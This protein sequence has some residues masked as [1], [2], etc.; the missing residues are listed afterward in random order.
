MNLKEMLTLAD[1]IIFTKSGQHLDDLQKTIL[2]GTL[3]RKTY[4]EI[5]KNIDCSESR[6]REIGAELWET[7]SEELGEKVK[8]TNFI[9][10]MERLQISISSKYFA[11]QES[12]QIGY[13]NYCV[14][15]K[16]PSNTQNQTPP[17]QQTT[18]P[19]QTPTLNHDLSEMPNLGTFYNR[20]SELQILKTSILTENAQLLTIT[21]IIGIG[22]TALA[23]S[24]VQQLKNN[25]EYVIWRSLETSP[26]LPQLQTNLIEIFT[27]QS[28]QNTPQPLIKY[29]QKHR[30][31]IILDDI[32]HIFSSQQ[33]SGEY[34][35]GYEDYRSFFKQIK[36]LSHQ[37][38]ILLIGREVPR[39]IAQLN[40]KNTP[41]LILRGL[42]ISAGAEI[43]KEQGL[44]LKNSSE[45]LINY[46]QGNPFWLKIVANFMLELG[47]SVT[48]LLENPSLFPQDLKDIL[49][50]EFER[51][52]EIEKQVISLLVAEN[53]PI[54]LVQLLETGKI[55]SSELPNALLSLSRGSIIEKQQN[56]YTLTL[57]LQQ[58]LITAI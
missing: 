44:E 21:G 53:Q 19:Q 51:L 39:E 54:T 55:P 10:A 11:P 25:F 17:N 7:L 26:T 47:L 58:Y 24:L 3:Q 1:E 37:S 46:C 2:R 5:A 16:Q 29:L 33:F 38:C 56:L 49:K 15:A 4:K 6:I 42:D 22:K 13:I 23:T 20:T 34:K 43:I 9:A 52:S 30:C 8:K 35:P 40:N 57:A 18:N 50:Q 27:Q 14:E 41:N 45:L 48:E 28:H 32:H 36:D 31:L 12:F